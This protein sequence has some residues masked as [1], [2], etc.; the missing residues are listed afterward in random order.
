VKPVKV[1]QLNW[2]TKVYKFT[3]L[4]NT[5][6][7]RREDI[8][9]MGKSSK[10]IKISDRTHERLRR[11]GVFEDTFDSVISRVLDYYEQGHKDKK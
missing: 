2:F 6:M 4:N 9:E 10:L 8:N 11:I 5:N 1:E 3:Q 7:A